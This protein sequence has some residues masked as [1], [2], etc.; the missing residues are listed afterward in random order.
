MI[1]LRK[2]AC[3]GVRT[4]SSRE[5][6]LPM[7]LWCVL[8]GRSPEIPAPDWGLCAWWLARCKY[9]WE[10]RGGGGVNLPWYPLVNTT[11]CPQTR[12]PVNPQNTITSHL[13]DI[14]GLHIIDIRGR[15]QQSYL[16]NSVSVYKTTNCQMDHPLVHRRIMFPDYRYMIL[17]PLLPLFLAIPCTTEVPEQ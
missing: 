15:L 4:D 9:A 17:K 5:P 3:T 6:W 12:R 10:R 11:D 2:Y 8:A 7:R 14:A 13:H 16:Y 1:N